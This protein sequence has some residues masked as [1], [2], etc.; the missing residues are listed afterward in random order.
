MDECGEGA[1]VLAWPYQPEKCPIS[2]TVAGQV[3][4]ETG[5]LDVVLLHSPS[6]ELTR[7]TPSNKDGFLFDDILW[8]DGA[9]MEHQAF[10]RLLG[11]SG[12]RTLLL[13]DLLRTVVSDPQARDALV[14]DA[15]PHHLAGRARH[16][17]AEWLLAEPDPVLCDHLIA[18]VTFD[19][20]P[21]EL[22][23]IG[24]HALPHEFVIPPLPN[25]FFVRDSSVWVRDRLLV[26]SMAKPARARE[27]SILATVY[28][29][30]PLF[31]GSSARSPWPSGVEGGDILVLSEDVLVLAASERSSLV[32][33][34]DLARTLLRGVVTECVITVLPKMRRAMHLDTVLAMADTDTC[35]AFVDLVE[36]LPAYRVTLDASDRLR[37]LD[38]GP[39]LKMMRCLSPDGLRVVGCPGDYY[40]REREQWADATNVLALSPGVVVS[41][42]HNSR[43]NDELTRI[44][45][46]VRTIRGSE[47]GRG[48]GGPRC[49]TSPIRRAPNTFSAR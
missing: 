47:L 7:L 34:E 12:V 11:E 31:A 30:H 46:E 38:E 25:Q 32:A 48:R 29:Y 43:T 20:L 19:E 42:E 2:A 9:A 40:H 35:V 4:S 23:L 37:L 3:D 14:A 1:P 26:T 36:D 15:L 8:P 10:V 6:A 49:M 41:Y 5:R 28:R 21:R 44:G 45:I 17:L 18:G 13:G 24:H 27:R 16:P 39:L 33:V 22:T